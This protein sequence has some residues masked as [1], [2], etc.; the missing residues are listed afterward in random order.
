M[1]NTRHD[2]CLLK[3]DKDFISR[4]YLIRIKSKNSM[5]YIYIYIYCVCVCPYACV[6]MCV[7]G[8]VGFMAYQ[9]L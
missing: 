4:S 3:L 5:L 8:L 6:F 1:G 7:C 9:P 2:C